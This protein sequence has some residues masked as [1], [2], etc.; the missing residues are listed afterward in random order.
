MQRGEGA[1]YPSPPGQKIAYL[2]TD[3]AAD[4]INDVSTTSTRSELTIH[5]NSMRV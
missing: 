3:P 2:L 4:S 5:L 1:G